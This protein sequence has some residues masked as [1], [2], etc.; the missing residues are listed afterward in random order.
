MC[1][2]PFPSDAL[3][4]V[5]P[6]EVRY[7]L[8]DRYLSKTNGLDEGPGEEREREH[9]LGAFVLWRA[10]D[11]LALLGRVPY[12]WKEITATP[13]G[14]ASSKERSHGLGDAEALALVGLAHGGGARPSTLGLVLGFTAPTGS[15]DARDA[16]GA[17]LDAH[18]QP[19][20]GAWSGAAGL[21]LGVAIGS[22]TIAL[23]VLGRANGENS[24]GYRYGDVLLYNAEW[25]SAPRNAW[26]LLLGANGR[27]ARRDRFEDGTLGE[28]TGGSVVY[29]S[30][31]VRWQSDQGL[32][33]EAGVQ[34]PVAQSLFGVQ[35][36]RA[37]ARLAMSVSR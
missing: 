30:P 23:S 11:R 19:G 32:G 1:G 27:S 2:A 29:L 14:E 9:R 16:S 4:G 13:E 10:M 21:N 34:V 7:G 22:Q 37:T 15:S 12:N 17:R 33:I 26:Q 3:G 35:H 25:T 5:V 31:G 24:H 20:A 28:N 6:M 8:E 18:L 36:E